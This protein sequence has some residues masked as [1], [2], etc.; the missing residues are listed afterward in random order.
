M[1]HARAPKHFFLPPLFPFSTWGSWLEPAVNVG[2]WC[3]SHA[4]PTLKAL[5]S[6]VQ[7]GS[8]MVNVE[9]DWQKQLVILIHLYLPISPSLSPSAFFPAGPFGLVYCFHLPADHLYVAHGIPSLC[10]V[11][12]FSL[13][14]LHPFNI[15][16]CCSAVPCL[17]LFL[18]DFKSGRF[19]IQIRYLICTAIDLENLYS[20]D[21]NYLLFVISFCVYLPCKCFMSLQNDD[22]ICVFGF[23]REVMENT[24]HFHSCKIGVFFS[25]INAKVHWRSEDS[26]TGYGKKCRHFHKEHFERLKYPYSRILY[27]ETGLPSCPGNTSH[28]HDT[29]SLQ[30]HSARSLCLKWNVLPI[31]QPMPQFFPPPLGGLH[32]RQLTGTWVFWI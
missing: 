15:P 2:G 21:F 17:S 13:S 30:K 11:E 6:K 5:A 14:P 28:P 24:V 7:E 12:I 16:C 18:L 4:A 32:S 1:Y 31:Q 19:E 23:S 10:S 8:S 22:V 3:S 9:I 27:R 25:L 26:H 29:A 20:T